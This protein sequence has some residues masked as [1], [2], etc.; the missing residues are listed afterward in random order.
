MG[1]IKLASELKDE[2][3]AKKIEQEDREGWEGLHTDLKDKSLWAKTDGNDLKTTKEAISSI[4]A[5][6]GRPKSEV[7]FKGVYIN[8][9][10]DLL[11]ELKSE[12]LKLNIGYQSYIKLSLTEQLKNKKV[13]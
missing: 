1:N 9:P 4:K 10:I 2:K 12:A 13:S 11:E 7:E 8:L 5:T 6:R 3:L